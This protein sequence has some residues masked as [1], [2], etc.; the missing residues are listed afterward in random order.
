[1]DGL[2]RRGARPLDGRGAGPELRG[3][4][5]RAAIATRRAVRLRILF[6]DR[7]SSM[8]SLYA[9]LLALLAL[10]APTAPVHAASFE[11]AVS[12]SRFEVGGKA[13]SR[14]GQSLNIFNVGNTPTDVAIRTLDWTYS[15]EGNVAYHDEL[16]PGS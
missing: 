1:P 7:G 15:P 2:E 16:L 9:P 10:C 6:R 11:V 12:P 14:V 5:A 4:P 13:A 3:R 8:K